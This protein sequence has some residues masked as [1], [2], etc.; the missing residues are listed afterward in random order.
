MGTHLTL[1]AQRVEHLREYQDYVLAYRLRALIGGKVRPRAPQLSLPEYAR[2]RLRRQTLARRV[3]TGEDYRAT[4]GAVDQLTDA[5]NFGFWH[6]PS[7]ALAFLRQVSRQGGHPAL[8]SPQAF[9][10]HLL[11]PL[12]RTRL[13]PDEEALIGRYYLGLLYSAISCLDPEAFTRLRDELEPLRE[14]L[15]LFLSDLA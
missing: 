6:N 10:D 4:L 15:P 3:L 9:I 13:G 8:A 14:R 12:E 11:T 5:L 2:K 7:E 1:Y